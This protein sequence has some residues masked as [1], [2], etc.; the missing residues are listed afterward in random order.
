MRARNKY[1][2]REEKNYGL[3]FRDRAAA[4][5][6]RDSHSAAKSVIELTQR[7]PDQQLTDPGKPWDV[8][9]RKL[10]FTIKEEI[11]QCR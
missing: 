7:E 11:R 5:A 10:R 6:G 4:L 3:M 2:E 9:Q 1:H 8:R